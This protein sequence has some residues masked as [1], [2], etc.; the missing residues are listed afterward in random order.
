LAS[1]IVQGDTPTGS[2]RSAITVEGPDEG[3]RSLVV[4]VCGLVEQQ[5]T[6]LR[7]LTVTQMPK[8][9]SFRDRLLKEIEESEQLIRQECLPR[10]AATTGVHEIRNYTATFLPRPRGLP[11]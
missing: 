10:G 5:Q 3:T 9:D 6:Q 1:F 8:G 7:R 4:R 11:F 2:K